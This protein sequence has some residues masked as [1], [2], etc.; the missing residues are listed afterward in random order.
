MKTP[1]LLIDTWLSDILGCHVFKLSI[2]PSEN[3]S[4]SDISTRI[5]E[6]QCSAPIFIYAKIPTDKLNTVH[7]LES[8]GFRLVDT[9]VVFERELTSGQEL[10][11]CSDIRL[12]IDQ[13]EEGVKDLAGRSISVSRFHLD[14]TIPTDIANGIKAEWAGNYFKGERGNAMIV[15]SIDGKIVGFLQL[16]RSDDDLTIDLMAVNPNY[17]RKRVAS[18]M[19]AFTQNRWPELN[20]IRAGT[21]VANSPSMQL[22][23]S[24]RFTVIRSDYILHFHNQRAN[25]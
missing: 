20:H 5:N 21:Q 22:Y 15:S 12:A 17:R 1:N 25:R 16:L 4:E 3:L 9:L 24:L 6:L 2:A 14:P 7:L 13:D 11:G 18:D 10:S 8:I 19:I 23:Q